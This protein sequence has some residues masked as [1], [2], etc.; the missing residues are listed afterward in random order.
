MAIHQTT[1]FC[2]IQE[3]PNWRSTHQLSSYISNTSMHSCFDYSTL[4][5]VLWLKGVF[6]ESSN[7]VSNHTA[8]WSLFDHDAH[9]L[10]QDVGGSHCG[11]LSVGVVCRLRLAMSSSGTLTATST[12]S[13]ATRLRCSR[14]RMM[15]RSSRVDQPPVSGVPVAGATNYQLCSQLQYSQ[16]GSR[17][18]MSIDRY[19]G[20]SVPTRS[21][22]LLM[23]PSVEMLSIS[24]ASTISKPQ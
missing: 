19:T 2:R 13:A 4:E 20:F 11:E 8:E 3:C 1:R 24:R 9:D 6:M 21:M 15:V 22:I 18:S 10:V 12:M 16:A 5:Y 23:I 7:L 17:V 14:P